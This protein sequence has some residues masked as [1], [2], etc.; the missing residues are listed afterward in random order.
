MLT[1]DDLILI[2][3]ELQLSV[4]SI[5]QFIYDCKKQ[6][7]SVPPWALSRLDSYKNALSHVNLRLGGD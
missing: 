2:R 6:G 4:I 7:G 5:K 1:H 3:D